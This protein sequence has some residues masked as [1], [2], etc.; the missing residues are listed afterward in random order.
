LPINAEFRDALEPMLARIATLTPEDCLSLHAAAMPARQ[1]LIG[2][3]FTPASSVAHPVSVPDAE[4]TPNGH[5]EIARTGGLPPLFVV[6]RWSPIVQD[7]LKASDFT[8]TDHMAREYGCAPA[9]LEQIVTQLVHMR[10]LE[11]L[12]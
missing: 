1:S 2:V 12:H 6:A 10:V 5:G 11:Q 9:E 4:V 7:L 8:L 3:R